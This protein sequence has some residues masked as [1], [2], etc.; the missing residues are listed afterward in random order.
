MYVG[1]YDY[2]KAKW[3]GERSGHGIIAHVLEDMR[4]ATQI[5][6]K[7]FNSRW[8]VRHIQTMRSKTSK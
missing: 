7:R 3:F 8:L 6:S 5:T 2:M 4:S 1:V